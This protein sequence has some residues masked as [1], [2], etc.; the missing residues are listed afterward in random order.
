MSAIVLMTT[1]YYYNYLSSEL[2]LSYLLLS[3]GGLFLDQWE[4]LSDGS[5]EVG[6]KANVFWNSCFFFKQLSAVWHTSGLFCNVSALSPRLYAFFNKD[7]FNAGL[8]VIARILDNKT[9][10]RWSRGFPIS[11][12]LQTV[13]GFNKYARV[14][15]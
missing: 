5:C 6:S 15:K 13:L 9:C 4:K 2:L 11:Q 14:N 8:T 3:Y 12:W 1:Y 10:K 7:C